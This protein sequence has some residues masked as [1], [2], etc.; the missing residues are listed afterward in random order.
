MCHEAESR[1]AKHGE[2]TI[3]VKI[4][5]WTNSIAQSKGH[6]A[7]KHCWPSGMVTVPANKSH[8]IS[9]NCPLPFRS[10]IDI[11]NVLERALIEWT[12]RS[13]PTAE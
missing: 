9:S 3:E 7:P 10:L 8:E 4:R 1:E 11:P 2:K 13:T 5:F 12:L 6:I